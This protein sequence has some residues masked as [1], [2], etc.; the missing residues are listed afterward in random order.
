MEK[1][2]IIQHKGTVKIDEFNTVKDP[3][4]ICDY[5]LDNMVNSVAVSV[6]F[7]SDTYSYGRNIGIMEYEGSWENFDVETF[8]NNY[9]NENTIAD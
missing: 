9:L 7:E 3:N 6:K 5:T 2:I 8:I 4:V 1:Q